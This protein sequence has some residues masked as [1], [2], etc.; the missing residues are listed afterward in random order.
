[1]DCRTALTT[2][3]AYSSARR[4]ERGRARVA[5]AASH[6]AQR[7][8]EHAAHLDLR[9]PDGGADL[10]LAQ[11]EE[12]A[13][14]D[15][16]TLARVER[17]RRGGDEHARDS[18]V[19]RLGHLGTGD[20]LCLAVDRHGRTQ[21][22]HQSGVA[23]E[24]A[25][26]PQRI[27]AVAEMAPDLPFD[28]DG[29]VRGELTLPA[30]FAAVDGGDQRNSADLH[31]IVERLAAADEATRDRANERQVTLDDA[32]PLIRHEIDARCFMWRLQWTFV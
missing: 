4:F 31:E 1:V 27:A 29:R 5:E 6:L 16:E 14:R 11:V 28:A 22:R 32:S 8:L 2:L 24:V 21:L 13:Q 30:A 20:Q 18:D 25:R 3:R 10:G 23:L 19:V 15:D 26:D 9:Q 17:A 7:T 12:V